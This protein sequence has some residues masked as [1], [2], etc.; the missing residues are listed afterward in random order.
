MKTKLLLS[1]IAVSTT[2]CA[3]AADVS[4]SINSGTPQTYTLQDMN[5]NSAGNI[6]L[7][8]TGNNPGPTPTPV[9]PVSC[10]NFPANV[11]N[12][13]LTAQQFPRTTYTPQPT[14]VTSFKITTGSVAK[15]GGL[16]VAVGGSSVGGMYV[17]LSE[18]TANFTQTLRAFPVSEAGTV[19][20]H[21]LRPDLDNRPQSVKLEPNKVY[22]FSV[23][24]RDSPTG[25]P[26]CT[27]PVSCSF[28]FSGY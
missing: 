18:C 10:T 25:Q 13:N 6:T 16:S 28:Y 21:V 9:P 11:V 22:Y 14:Q 2:M 15:Q 27:T 5:V 3:H 4:I 24:K 23:A 26:N 19:N 7:R 12:T 8:V 20:Y 17:S 1:A